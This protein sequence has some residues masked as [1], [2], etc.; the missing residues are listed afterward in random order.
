MIVLAS[1]LRYSRLVK[2]M[3]WPVQ[4]GTMIVCIVLLVLAVIAG[5]KTWRASS[6]RVSQAA[7]DQIH[8]GMTRVEVE[9]VFDCPEANV[10]LDSLTG[11]TYSK[12]WSICFG[13]WRIS[14]S[15]YRTWKSDSGVVIIVFN[16][17]DEV[18]GMAYEEFFRRESFFA[19]L[20]E[21]S[22]LRSHFQS[23]RE[24]AS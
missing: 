21:W 12:H 16:E 11:C 19:K 5:L 20:F 24:P 23:F 22:G 17:Q 8:F 13:Q 2:K 4:G 14:K 1:L 9:A 6:Q 10:D 15:T 3:L 18:V 7:Y